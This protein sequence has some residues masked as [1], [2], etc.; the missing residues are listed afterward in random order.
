MVLFLFAKIKKNG[1][2]FVLVLEQENVRKQ[3]LEH[4]D[5]VVFK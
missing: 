3:V 2:C 4:I 5:L 1:S